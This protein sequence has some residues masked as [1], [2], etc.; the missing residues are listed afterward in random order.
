M[1][2]FLGHKT[3]Q[4]S[5]YYFYKSYFFVANFHCES[6]KSTICV[7]FNKMSISWHSVRVTNIYT[8]SRLGLAH[9]WYLCFMSDQQSRWGFAQKIFLYYIYEST[10]V[11]NRAAK[12]FLS[13][14]LSRYY[15][16]TRVTKSRSG[17]SQNNTCTMSQHV[18]T[19]EPLSVCSHAITVLYVWVT[20]C[21]QPSRL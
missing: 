17:L 13:R 20:T 15:E 11:D 16:P 4:F 8:S 12:G 1:P 6:S 14:N 7:H 9:T 21:D 3:I 2:G 10:W 19:P 5:T 18:W